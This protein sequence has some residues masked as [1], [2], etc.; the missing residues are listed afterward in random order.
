V[1]SGLALVQALGQVGAAGLDGARSGLAVRVG[2]DTGMVLVPSGVGVVAQLSLVVGSPL[3]Q[4][5]QLGGWAR[6]G[7]VVVSE[8][9]AQLVGGYF[10]CKALRNPVLADQHEVRV[11]YE[12]LGVSALQ[13]RLD[14]GIARG[15][16]P[17]VGRAAELALLRDRWTSA[18][19]GMGQVVL[20]RGKRALANPDWCTPCKPRWSTSSASRWYVAVPRTI[21]TRCCI[22]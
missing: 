18:Q 8:A 3:T 15:L 6:P 1:R 14:I 11:V 7:T 19:E 22:R 4:A 17:F 10:D 5:M 13:T 9:T 12:V 20:L 16:T 21:N 2:I